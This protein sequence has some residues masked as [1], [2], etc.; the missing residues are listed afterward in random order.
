MNSVSRITYPDYDVIKITPIE[1]KC[2][3]HEEFCAMLDKN[4]GDIIKFLQTLNCEGYSYYDPTKRKKIVN[5]Y[6]NLQIYLNRSTYSKVEVWCS[7]SQC[8]IAKN[9]FARFPTNL[10][11]NDIFNSKLDGLYSKRHF[12]AVKSYCK[13]YLARRNIVFQSCGVIKT[14]LH[15]ALNEIRILQN[16]SKYDP[17]NSYIIKLHEV[18][19]SYPQSKV[20]GK[21]YLVL[22]FCPLGSSMRL[23]I[24]PRN[25]PW[26]SFDCID[27]ITP[28]NSTHM[29]L[30]SYNDEETEDSK[31]VYVSPLRSG[32]SENVVKK[33]TMCA[34]IAIVKLHELDIV[35]RDIKPDNFLITSDGNVVLADFNSAEDISKTNGLIL[36]TS[37]TYAFFPPECC[38]I[39]N[40][41]FQF[42]EIQGKP[43]DMWALGV[44]IWCWLYGTLPFQ[45]SSILELFDEIVKCQYTFPDYPKLSSQGYSTINHLLDPDP[46]TRWTA[47]QLLQSDWLNGSKYCQ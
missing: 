7:I 10:M 43:T 30:S 41:R 17:T 29:L 12:Y 3:L 33:F 5:Q 11:S 21:L 36:Q 13:A 22:D 44:T 39:N 38:D 28:R 32:L 20:H 19:D 26:N 24:P 6:I 14:Q 45:G 8:E 40:K 4:E 16:I 1:K 27:T 35:H 18:L 31:L 2:E 46:K 37:G 9:I 25:H 15:C 23:T 42:D 34:A 47:K